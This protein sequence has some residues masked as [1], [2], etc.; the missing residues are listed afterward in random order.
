MIQTIINTIF[1]LTILSIITYFVLTKNNFLKKII[2]NIRIKNAAKKEAKKIIN[3]IKEQEKIMMEQI[4]QEARIEAMK[5]IKPE[6]VNH[7]KSQEIKKLTG[8]DKKEKMEKFAMLF[9]AGKNN[10]EKQDMSEKI[11]KMLGYRQEATFNTAI[12][13]KISPEKKKNNIPT[14]DEIISYFK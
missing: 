9:G 10:N 6:L 1:I 2:D 3:E 11:N 14:N 4:K 7:Y 13:K 5:N 12:E 8:D